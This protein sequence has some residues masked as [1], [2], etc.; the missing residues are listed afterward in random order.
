MVR[1]PPFYRLICS[2]DHETND[3]RRRHQT[4]SIFGCP[5]CDLAGREKTSG[6]AAGRTVAQPPLAD[7]SNPF[8]PAASLAAARD[9]P[10]DLQSTPTRH[11]PVIVHG[12]LRSIPNANPFNQITLFHRSISAKSP[13]HEFSPSNSRNQRRLL[14]RLRDYTDIAGRAT[15]TERHPALALSSHARFGI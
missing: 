10:L 1:R 8:F 14:L 11:C 13:S 5:N 6:F 9:R 3:C 7:K 12:H 2:S 15:E 4:S